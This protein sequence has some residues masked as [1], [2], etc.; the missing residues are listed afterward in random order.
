MKKLLKLLKGHK[1][2]AFL[3]FEGTQ[4]S[5]EMIAIGAVLVSI[6]KNGEVKKWK[7]PF[8]RYVKAKNKIGKYVS[9]LTGINQKTLDSEGISFAK[10]MLDLKKYI[11]LHF[12]KAT[13]ITFGNH[14]M[15]ILGQS[16]AYNL[17][18]PKDVCSQIQKN[19]LDYSV[20]ISEF[21]KDSK[22]NPLSLVHY[23]ELFDVELEGP[24][25]DPSADAFNLAKLYDAF[26]QN[27]EKVV[28]EY[29]LALLKNSRYPQPVKILLEK[30]VNGETVTPDNLEEEIRE[31]IA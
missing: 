4:F 16:I 30:I 2:I 25:H 26:L 22:G 20:F 27:K 24:N 28:S 1:H 3:D 31:Y 21:V 6:G 9:E 19:Y 15:R 11:G 5:H 10:A 29:K 23:C 12:K 14:D 17:D 18:F 13:F 7:K 8:K